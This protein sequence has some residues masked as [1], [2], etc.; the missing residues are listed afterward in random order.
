[1]PIAASA[2]AERAGLPPVRPA[3]GLYARLLA[4]GRRQPTTPVLPEIAA[5]L[6]AWLGPALA[7]AAAT[8]LVSG[9]RLAQE[10]I[11]LDRLIENTLWATP[12]GLG[13]GRSGTPIVLAPV[14][15][16]KPLQNAAAA[17]SGE[18]VLTNDD[19]GHEVV[20]TT[21]AEWSYWVP[22]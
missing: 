14:V 20:P 18:I 1:I 16:Q 9:H 11:G 21:E 2:A 10:A 12:A 19:E 7:S 3:V 22:A 13:P 15:T 17:S 6:A 4:V 5:E 8:L